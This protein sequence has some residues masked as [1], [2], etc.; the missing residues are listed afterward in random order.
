MEHAAPGLEYVMTVHLT[1]VPGSLTRITDLPGGGARWSINVG[2]GSFEGP[3]L[4]GRVLP[5]GIEN[6]HFRPDNVLM[7]NARWLLETDDGERIYV[8]NRGIRRAYHD[9]AKMTAWMTKSAPVT[10]SDFYFRV[11]PV[12]E[13]SSGKYDWLTRFLFVGML[14]DADKTGD[15]LPGPSMRYFK[16]L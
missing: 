16:V 12:F 15:A 5:G 9:P 7:I 4:K 1:M 6:P 10:A 8:Q 3:A 11:A 14:I 13:T 2:G